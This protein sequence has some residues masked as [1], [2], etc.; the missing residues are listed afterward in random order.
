[1]TD[2]GQSPAD[3]ELQIIGGGRMGEA[4]LAGLLDAGWAT[5]QQLGVVEPDTERR[6]IL[7]N[8]YPGVRVSERPGPA[9]GVVVAVK[10]AH[11]AEVCADLAGLGVERILSI[12]AGVTTGRLESAAGASLPVVRAMPNTPA[13][14]GAGASAVAAGTHAGEDDLVWAE[15]ILGSVGVTVRVEEDLLDAVTGLSGSGPAYVFLLV[16]ALIDAGVAQGLSRDVAGALVVQTVAGAAEI[17]GRSGANG[18]D[19]GEHR[20]AVTSPHGTTAAGLAVFEGHDVRAVVAEAV[21]AATERSRQLG[22]D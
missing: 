19:A 8:R 6:R 21:A 18:T 5:P 17:L 13:Q 9:R 3:V 4:L 1:M 12:A 7:G 20:E 2:T 10:P 14:V 22:A 16:E 15:S 11:A